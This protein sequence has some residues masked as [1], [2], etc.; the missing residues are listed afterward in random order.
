MSSCVVCLSVQCI[1]PPRILIIRQI[2]YYPGVLALILI[3]FISIGVDFG[4]NSPA[5]F[6]GLSD[7]LPDDYT[8]VLPAQDCVDPCAPIANTVTVV[9]NAVNIRSSPSFDAPVVGVLPYNAIAE[10][11]TGVTAPPDWTPIVLSD[12]TVGYVSQEYLR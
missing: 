5:P 1:C 8:G 6:N 7:S 11:A 9:A 10:V 4:N 2:V 3:L 12:R